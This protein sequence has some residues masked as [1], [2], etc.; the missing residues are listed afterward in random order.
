MTAPRS[1]PLLLLA[2]T[3]LAHAAPADDLRHVQRA[4]GESQNR[5]QQQQQQQRRLQNE[6]RQTQT[7]LDAARRELDELT[8]RRQ[9]VWREVQALQNTLETLQTRIGGTQA[10]VARLLDSRYRNRQPNAVT[11][12]L[13]NAD[14]QQKGRYLEY[15]R[16]LNQ[17]NDRAL[18]ELRQSQQQA[19]QQQE[20]VNR[21]LREL[22]E[23]K[24]R[25]QAAAARLGREQQAQQQ[26]NRELEQ[27]ISRETARLNQLRSNERRLNGVVAA[28]TRRATQRRTE[29]AARQRAAQAQRQRQAEQ[30]RQAE[31]HRR[32]QTAASDPNPSAE[33]PAPQGNL[34]AEDL[35]L[36]PPA[37]E[38]AAPRH[39]FSRLQ[40]SLRRPVSGSIAG[41]FGQSRPGGGTWK[42]VF[43][44]TAPAAVHSIA[45]GEVAYA[46]PLQGYG[47]TVIIDHGD[48][49]LSIYT[50]LSQISAGN[51][52]QVSARQP[53]GR[54]GSLPD[55]E[56]GLYFEIRYR[57]QAM[58]PL[59]WVN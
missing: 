54:S 25:Q 35:N 17:A 32:A 44:R 33:P 14:P 53:I 2:C 11:L 12:F 22:D 8:R 40:G 5:L 4:I 21:Q 29:E 26:Q 41:Q 36:A 19:R 27:N 37:A 7:Q 3:A 42:G 31:A 58:N 56:S 28:I 1:L 30:R 10:Q 38:T 50:G 43:I 45:A 9:S 46:A 20:A 59:S 39:S 49:Y 18:S 6:L 15:M 34:T 55:G 48:G 47:N 51:G 52:S 23:L 13:Q 16:Y 24:R 57:N